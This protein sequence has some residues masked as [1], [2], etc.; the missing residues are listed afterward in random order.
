MI[1]ALTSNDL[2][3]Y[4][5]TVS[6]LNGNVA[7]PFSVDSSHVVANLRCQYA[8]FAEGV[9]TL[10]LTGPIGAANNISYI[11][12]QTGTGTTFVMSESA[13]INTPTLKGPIFANIS[14]GGLLE[15]PTVSDTLVG[16][17]TTDTLTNKTLVGA[18]LNTPAFVTPS[19]ANISNVGLITLPTMTTT[20]VGTNTTDTL[21]NK[22]LTNPIINGAN[23]SSA[24]I[25]NP[26]IATIQNTGL[27]TLPTATTTL[28]GRDTTDTLTNKDLR[29]PSNNV[30]A[31][32][33]FNSNGANAVSFFASGQPSAGYYLIADSATTASWMP[34]P[35]V[36][37]GNAQFSDQSFYVYD[38]P[39]NNKQFI[40]DVQGS[41]ATHT[42]LETSQTGNIVVVLPSV[43]DTLVG[44]NTTDTLTN[45]VLITP[46]IVTP[47]MANISNTGLISFPTITDT[48]VGRSTTDTLINKTLTLPVI[49]S[50]SNTGIL[51]LPTITDTLVGKNTTDSL[52]NKTLSSSTNVVYA[53]KL[54]TDNGVNSVDVKA[55][56]SP[57]TG[58]ALIATDSMHATWQSISV[59]SG[60]SISN[61]TITGS[62]LTAN[63][64][65]IIARSLWAG[66]GSDSISV[67][68]AAVPSA[69]QVLTATS[70]ST[71]NWQTPSGGGGGSATSGASDAAASETFG[72]S[73]NSWAQ[74]ATSQSV[75]LTITGTFALVNMSCLG[76]GASTSVLRMG[77]D[78]TGAS[79]VAASTLNSLDMR[80]TQTGTFV[81][82]ASG[83]FL[84]TGLTPGVNTFTAYFRKSTGTTS[85]SNRTFS[86]IGF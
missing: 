5:R 40:I 72:G 35:I 37:G 24:V 58:Q 59:P 73:N 44:R 38:Y 76:S 61:A 82:A 15:L 11:T 71:A 43:S 68:A 50:I 83:S 81:I 39:A 20:L 31:R 27:I 6:V 51:T 30:I 26:T 33:L 12:S 56:A 66:S 42:T 25:D 62:T 52:T 41:A 19:F 28:V 85:F 22:T 9:G 10:N 75:T 21:T 1:N 46:N 63:T 48:L 53:T 86:V 65:N 47:V 80:S 2:N 36:P 4:F 69:G 67:Y 49:S 84:V 64:N 78:V 70:S 17:N 13:T 74:L 14:N 54:F 18:I 55:A 32:S 16:R 34:A 7:P 77:F 23:I 8:Q 29:D 3:V 45:K 60:S 57:S 79:S